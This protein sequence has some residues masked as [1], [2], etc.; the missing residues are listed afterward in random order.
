MHVH[1]PRSGTIAQH[2]L[3][4]LH[5]EWIQSCSGARVRSDVSGLFGHT[6]LHCYHPAN[7]P[8]SPTSPPITGPI[9]AYA[10]KNAGRFLHHAHIIIIRLCKPAHIVS[11]HPHLNEQMEHV[12]PGTH[13]QT[14]H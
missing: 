6:R 3:N 9:A 13:T 2:S 1:Q 5:A 8:C 4:R 10:G 7:L 12:K 11:N 14:C